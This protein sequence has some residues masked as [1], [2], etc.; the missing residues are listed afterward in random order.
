MEAGKRLHNTKSVAP[1]PPAALP[2]GGDQAAYFFHEGTNFHAY[3]YLGV[4]KEN[5]GY[6]FRVWAP[7]AKEVFLV[8]DRFR[9]DTGIPMEKH[10]DA[11]V[12]VCFYPTAD[13][14]EG[15]KYKFK[16]VSS[17]GIR[18]KSDPYA[19]SSE[20]LEKTASRIYCDRDYPW[21]DDAWMRERRRILPKYGSYHDR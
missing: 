4:T 20:T 16:I 2:E 1:Y 21:Q 15:E 9:W 14:L 17:G 13:S 18:Y 11:G 5:G 6:R 7:G 8:G 10:E 3:E 19:F 12:F